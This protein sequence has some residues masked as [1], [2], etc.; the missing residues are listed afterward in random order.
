MHP[1][2]ESGYFMAATDTGVEKIFFIMGNRIDNEPAP[3]SYLPFPDFFQSDC[4]AGG[5]VN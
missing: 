5:N 1:F 2:S 4:Q 3:L